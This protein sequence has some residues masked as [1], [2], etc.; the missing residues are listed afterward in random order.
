[1]R[2]PYKPDPA[3]DAWV[4]RLRANAGDTPVPP[5]SV[6]SATQEEIPQECY[7]FVGEFGVPTRPQMRTKRARKAPKKR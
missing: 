4:A 2:N 1:M 3:L 5:R 6:P 7:T